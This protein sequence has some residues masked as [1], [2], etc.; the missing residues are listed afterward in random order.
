VA[1]VAVALSACSSS[2]PVSGT[3][4]ASTPT[5]TVAA[6]VRTSGTTAGSL[7]ATAAATAPPATSADAGGSAVKDIERTFQS[8]IAGVAPA[9]VEISTASG[10]GSGIVYDAQ[11]H[12]VTNAHVVGD[13]TD[14]NVTFANGRKLAAKLVGT[15]PPDD[16]AVIK[17]T[18][19]NLPA[20][21]KFADSSKVR[22]GQFCLAIGNPLGLASSVTSGIVSFN[23]RTVSEGNGV[24]LPST[25]QTSAPINPGN[26]GGAL[27]DMDK[28]VIGI[29]TLAASDPQLG[30][31]AAPGIGFA[32]PSNTVTRIADQLIKSGQVTHSGRAALGIVGS[33]V[34]DATGAPAGV[35]VREVVSGSAA[36][37]AGIAAGDLIQ[38]IDGVATPDL[39]SLAEV[40]ARHQPG[41]QVNVQVVLPDDSKKTVAVTL[42]ELAS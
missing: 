22:V 13:S 24:V 26:S 19:S 21:P 9:V 34:Q 38:Q 35:L 2:K 42:G 30:G 41:D 10:L 1:A 15:Y 40:L 3:G 31:G 16:L 28:Q 14:F 29:P 6:T 7:D 17:V 39:A 20:P 23:G 18:G 36:G 33:D 4:G 32:I 12:I 27:V 8:V 5:S 11:G 25:I 37:K